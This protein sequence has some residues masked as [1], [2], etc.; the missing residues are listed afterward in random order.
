MKDELKDGRK[1]SCEK[2]HFRVPGLIPCDLWSEPRVTRAT[3]RCPCAPWRVALAVK[4]EMTEAH[5]NRIS[6]KRLGRV[7][8][9]ERR[10]KR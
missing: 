7:F 3:K 10:K 8:L 1:D 6:Y 2:R 5:I 4:R 9:S